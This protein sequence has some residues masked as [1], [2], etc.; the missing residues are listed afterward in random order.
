MYF[1][2]SQA[3]EAI[4]EYEPTP[5]VSLVSVLIAGLLGFI[6]GRKSARRWPVR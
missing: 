2:A 1:D 6:L 5:R 3:R 4:S